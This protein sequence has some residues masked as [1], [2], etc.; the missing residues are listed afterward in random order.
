[1][2]SKE[3]QSNEPSGVTLYNNQVYIC[4]RNN[5]RIQVFDTSLDPSALTVKEEV[6]G[7]IL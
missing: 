7:H 4:D 6:D 2:G 3:G 1:M 5:H